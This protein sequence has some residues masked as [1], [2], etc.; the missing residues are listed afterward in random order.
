ML[1]LVSPF[2]LAWVVYDCGDNHGIL[3]VFSA[4]LEGYC[5]LCDFQAMAL[6]AVSILKAENME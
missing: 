3:P 5:P 6:C 4:C 1:S 2:L